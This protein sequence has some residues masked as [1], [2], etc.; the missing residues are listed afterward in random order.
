MGSNSLAVG[1]A[2]NEI[3]KSELCAAPVAIPPPLPT[4][5]VT[6]QPLNEDSSL[7]SM[8]FVMSSGAEI[9]VRNITLWPKDLLEQ[10][11]VLM[12]Q[13]G[14]LNNGF[15]TGLGFIGGFGYVVT[16]SLL[17]GAAEMIVSGSMPAKAGTL[18]QQAARLVA[19]ASAKSYSTPVR[20]IANVEGADPKHPDR[21]IPMVKRSKTQFHFYW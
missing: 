1:F 10:A 3:Q 6:A 4:S 9:A 18:Q 8:V 20:N 16:R 17:L 19:E 12:D 15:S 7:K 11:A 21:S 2:G 5:A 14:V 13:A